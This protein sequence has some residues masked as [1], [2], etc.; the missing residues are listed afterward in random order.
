MAREAGRDPA[1]LEVSVFGMRP[2]AG[3]LA[4]AREA[5]VTRCILGL[6]PEPADKVLPVLD[7][8]AA[9]VHSVS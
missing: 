9:L 2:E 7:R 5:G 3:E 6:A 8:Y 1:A 4:K